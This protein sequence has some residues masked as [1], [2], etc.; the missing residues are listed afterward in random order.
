MRHSSRIVIVGGGVIGCS[1]AYHLAKRG[2]QVHLLER[3]EMGAQASGAAAGLFSWLKPMSKMDAYNRL[4]LA[5]RNLFPSLVAELEEATGI[6]VEY[7][8]CGTLRTIQHAVRIR[9]VQPWARACQ[10]AGLQVALLTEAETRQ[11]EPL[12]APEIC[13]AISFPDEGQVR[14]TRMVEALAQAARSYGAT[15]RTHT[16]VVGVE[17]AHGRVIAVKTA[18]GEALPCDHLII[19]SGAW[20]ADC[21]AWL[22][23][24]LPISPERGQV[25]ALHQPSSPIRHI[26][27]GKGIYIAPKQD[28]TVIVGATK[29]DVGFDARN[30]AG[31]VLWLLESACQLVPELASCAIERIWAGLRPRTPDR[32]PILG[33]APG[34]ENVTLAVGH[35]SFGVLLSAITGHALAE[36]LATGQTPELIRP[37]SLARF[38]ATT[39]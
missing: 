1:I 15:L 20:A 37:F 25:L 2:F 18:E 32:E 11:L 23:R 3:D 21:G 19:A 16:A 7:E 8:Q 36:L 28:G 29:D 33:A 26:L 27:I 9:R 6:V 12:L 24:T 39:A 17:Q 34:W 13:G 22:K 10:A 14:A 35:Y 31:G 5:S 38:A 4:L 30:T